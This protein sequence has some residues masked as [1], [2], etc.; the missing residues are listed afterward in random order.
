MKIQTIEMN[1][2][3]Y[4]TGTIGKTI[5]LLTPFPRFRG[6]YRKSRLKILQRVYTDVEFVSPTLLR[7]V[8]DILGDE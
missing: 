3:L 1:K 2:T 6:C 8:K 7:D 4:I 5:H